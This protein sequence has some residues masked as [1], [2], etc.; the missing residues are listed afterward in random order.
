MLN[1]LI[2]SF[3]LMEESIEVHKKVEMS[4]NSESGEL[5]MNVE[6]TQAQYN[7]IINELEIDPRIVDIG[8]LQI[9]A[10]GVR[11]HFSSPVICKSDGEEFETKMLG[12]RFDGLKVDDSNQDFSVLKRHLFGEQWHDAV[13]RQ[14]SRIENR[15]KRLREL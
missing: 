7:S 15:K 3:L 4:Y 2:S 11:I 8:S 5:L 1:M 6:N 10:Q 13:E 14:R 9:N 12:V